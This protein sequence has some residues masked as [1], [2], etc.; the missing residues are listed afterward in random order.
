MNFWNGHIN[1]FKISRFMSEVLWK[2]ITR[3]ANIVD[4]D[5]N[6]LN[7]QFV[8][9]FWGSARVSLVVIKKIVPVDIRKKCYDHHLCVQKFKSHNRK[10]CFRTCASSRLD[11]LVYAKQSSIFF[12]AVRSLHIFWKWL[13]TDN[14]DN[15]LVSL[16]RSCMSE[17]LLSGNVAANTFFFQCYGSMVSKLQ[18]THHNSKQMKPNVFTISDLP[19][20]SSPESLHPSHLFGKW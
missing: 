14:M 1:L 12:L 19:V 17:E 10:I 20:P 9:T 16:H 18:K 5:Q 7:L 11:H 4:P 15:E 8:H 6:V 3:W 2:R 13:C